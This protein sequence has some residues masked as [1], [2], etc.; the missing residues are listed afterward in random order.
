MFLVSNRQFTFAQLSNT[1]DEIFRTVEKRAELEVQRLTAIHERVEAADRT[2]QNGV[3][4]SSR[5]T[6][7]FSPAKFPRQ[8]Q[9]DVDTLFRDIDGGY[10]PY[11]E[12][13]EDVAYI[14]GEKKI[15]GHAP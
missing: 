12:R 6:Q 1:I 11:P 5:A 9:L 3:K 8:S 7:I 2:I 10:L 15:S 4:G 13:T 14:P